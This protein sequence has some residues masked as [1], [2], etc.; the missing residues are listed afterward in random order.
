MRAAVFDVDRTLL[1]GMSG[2][3]FARHLWRTGALPW[4]GR[5]R[6]AKAM[7]LYRL[8]LAGPEIIIAA[9]A[10]CC[11]GLTAARTEELADAAVAATMRGRFYREALAAVAAHRERGDRVLLASGSNVFVA[12]AIAR[13]AGAEDAVGTDCLRSDGRLLATMAGPACYAEGKRELVSRW[14]AERGLT[15]AETIVYTDNG[16]DRPLLEVAGEVVAVNPDADLARLAAARGWRTERWE[17]PV[18]PRYRRT[19]TSWPL[20]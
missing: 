17:T 6:S 12:R 11:A 1:D 14:L 5:W 8:G 18:D 10:T 20:R 2:F 19:G 13:A 3:L 7:V 16:I 15:P 9:G 4:R